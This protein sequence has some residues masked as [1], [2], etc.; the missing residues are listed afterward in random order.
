[1]VDGLN[2]KRPDYINYK[3]PLSENKNVKNDKL[4][5]R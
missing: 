3:K 1:M 4:V 2:S 5:V